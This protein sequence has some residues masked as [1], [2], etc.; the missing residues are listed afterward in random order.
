MA[1]TMRTIANDTATVLEMAVSSA[2][3]TATLDSDTLILR[4]EQLAQ[5]REVEKRRAAHAKQLKYPKK[6]SKNNSLHKRLDP[7]ESSHLVAP[8]VLIDGWKHAYHYKHIRRRLIPEMRLAEGHAEARVAHWAPPID[9]LTTPELPGERTGYRL[10]PNEIFVYEKWRGGEGSRGVAIRHRVYAGKSYT[11]TFYELVDGRGWAHDHCRD[12]PEGC[13]IETLGTAEA[14]RDGGLF[15]QTT[16]DF[17]RATRRISSIASDTLGFRREGSDNSRSST[18][19]SAENSNTQVHS[20]NA[21]NAQKN[22]KINS[23]LYLDRLAELKRR[24]G[25]K[26]FKKLVW[27]TD[28]TENEDD[29]FI[30]DDSS[31]TDDEA[32]EEFLHQIKCEAMLTQQVKKLNTVHEPKKTVCFDTRLSVVEI[33]SWRQ[34]PSANVIQLWSSKKEIKASKQRNIVEFES[35]GF[36]W[37]NALEED[38]F[39]VHGGEKIHPIHFLTDRLQRQTMEEN[40]LIERLQ[41]DISQ[42]KKMIALFIGTPQHQRK[43]SSTASVLEFDSMPVSYWQGR[44]ASK[45]NEVVHAA[46]AHVM[47]KYNKNIEED[48]GIDDSSLEDA[49]FSS[50]SIAMTVPKSGSSNL[51]YDDDYFSEDEDEIEEVMYSNGHNRGASMKYFSQPLDE[52][53]PHSLNGDIFF[54]ADR[55]TARRKQRQFELDSIKRRQDKQQ[56]QLVNNEAE[57]K[58]ANFI[59]LASKDAASIISGSTLMTDIEARRHHPE[60]DTLQLERDLA[61]LRSLARLINDL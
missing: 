49:K 60:K 17:V 16:N 47:E 34:L 61:K 33:E 41:Y 40:A 27:W 46:D 39:V 19:S 23:P 8:R 10:N 22:M 9:L 4:Q 36:D 53:N 13:T 26:K 15:A 56:R 51:I 11:I 48:T 7:K 43:T 6:L 20:I 42:T 24:I 3:L 52:K 44:F 45:E 57:E 38:S 21:Q 18:A 14:D 55:Q 50:S 25:K 37:R 30:I 5:K 35:E 58:Q 29:S 31:D 28:A 2:A 12:Q 54:E 1:T 32:S 59:A